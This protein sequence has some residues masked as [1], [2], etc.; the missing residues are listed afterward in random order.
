MKKIVFLLTFALAAAPVFAQQQEL[1]GDSVLST[2][3][4]SLLPQNVKMAVEEAEKES[5][6]GYVGRQMEEEVKIAYEKVAKVESSDTG[7]LLARLFELASAYEYFRQSDQGIKT[8]APFAEK[9]VNTPFKTKDE[10]EFL[11]VAFLGDNGE[12]LTNSESLQDQ[13]AKEI[14][15]E[16]GDKEKVLAAAIQLIN[17]G[18]HVLED[19]GSVAEEQQ[20]T[21]VDFSADD[22]FRT[23]SQSLSSFR[24]TAR[25]M[26]SE[27]TAAVVNKLSELADVVFEQ[28]AKNP[29]NKAEFTAKDSAA[30]EAIKVKLNEPF[31]VGWQQTTVTIRGYLERNKQVILEGKTSEEDIEKAKADLQKLE[32]FITA[33]SDE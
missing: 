13:F 23:V 24:A 17:W 2:I 21:P 5:N 33:L 18:K 11:A 31:P 12:K 26:T 14:G 32:T 27:N 4:S 30:F 10:K 6:N 8:L 28:Y 22:S 1:S 25:W 15:L 9:L 7:I 16:A 29:D 19:S 20:E 3:V